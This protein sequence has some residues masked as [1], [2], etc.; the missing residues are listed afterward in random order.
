MSFLPKFSFCAFI[1]VTG[2][3]LAAP[4]HAQTSQTSL[5]SG[6]TTVILGDATDRGNPQ[7]FK[8][9]STAGF[10]LLPESDATSAML[11]D[12]SFENGD[13]ERQPTLLIVSSDAKSEGGIPDDVELFAAIML[14]TSDDLFKKIK[15]RDTSLMTIADL[16]AAEVLAKARGANTGEKIK[17]VQWMTFSEGGRFIRLI[18]YAPKDEFD[19]ALPRFEEVRDGLM[20]TP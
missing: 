13:P 5:T 2:F 16:P 6:E 18:G 15:I 4:S 10:Q 17:I 3:L 19:A 8:L 14:Y 7:S 11:T 12:G 20:L 9:G 1:F